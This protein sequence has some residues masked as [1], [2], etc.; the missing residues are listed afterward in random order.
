MRPNRPPPSPS[1]RDQP[2]SGRPPDGTLA[3]QIALV[4]ILHEATL[5]ARIAD[6]RSLVE[7]LYATL[8]LAGIQPDK[9]H[10]KV[11]E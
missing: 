6:C 3:A 2:S 1:V 4:V 7:Q 5:N 8:R 11:G 9:I 10:M